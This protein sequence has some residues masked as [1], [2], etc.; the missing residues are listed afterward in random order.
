MPLAP[1]ASTPPLPL[2]GRMEDEV[3]PDQP[4][5]VLLPLTP[6]EGRAEAG[7]PDDDGLA[8]CAE[9]GRDAVRGWERDAA[10]AVSDDS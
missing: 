4:L 1:P 3:D 7:R 9:N 5:T 8:A 6:L 2:I 10:S